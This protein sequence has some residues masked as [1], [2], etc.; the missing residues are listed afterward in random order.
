MI[1][2][3]DVI[4]GFAYAG[5]AFP[6]YQV[7]REQ[8]QV[9]YDC[10]SDLPIGREELLNAFREAIKGSEF[11]PTVAAIRGQFK[12]TPTPPAYQALEAPKSANTSNWAEVARRTLSEARLRGLEGDLSHFGVENEES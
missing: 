1:T 6:N 10:F 7:T 8:V 3:E 5:A 12:S 4:A 11:F 2:L 9:Y